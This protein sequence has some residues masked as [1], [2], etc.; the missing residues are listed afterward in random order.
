MVKKISNFINTTLNIPRYVKRF[1][2]IT[3]D[4]CLSVISLWIAFYLR[5]DEFVY[6]SGNIS[7]VAL[8]SILISIPIFWMMNMY[9]SIFRY[10]G[11]SELITVFL[12]IVVYGM[13]FF[14]IIVIYSIP[15]I[16]RSIGILQPIVYFFAISASRLTARFILNEYSKTFKNDINIQNT[17]VYGAGLAGRQISLLL[18]KNV[19]IKVFGY[20]DDNVILQGQQINGQNIYS[21]E[22]AQNIIPK[23]KISHILLAIPSLSRNKRKKLIDKIEILKVKIQTLPSISDMMLGKLK[24]SDIKDLDIEDVLGRDSVE[25]NYKLLSRNTSDK[26]V[27]ITGAGGS[28]GSELCR[29]VLKL[30]PRNLILVDSSEHSLYEI[31]SEID[32]IKKNNKDY[33]RVNIF[34][35]LLSIRNLNHLD[36]IFKTFNPDT[37][38]HAA[39]Y[40]HVPIVEENVN[41]GIDN[42]VIGTL[43]LAKITLNNQVKDLVFIS[44]DKAV[45]PTNIMGASKRLSEICLQSLFKNQ[46]NKKTKLSIVRFGNV[47]NSSGSVIPK[48]KKQ[49]IDG[50]P[51]TLTHENVTRYFMTISE[52]AQLVIQ[53]GGLSSGNDIFLLDMGEPIKIK[54]LIQKVV[55]LSGLTLRDEKNLEGDIDIEIIGL[56][57]G[58]KLFEELLISNKSEITEHSKIFK[59]LDPFPEWDELKFKINALEN[60][61]NSGDVECSVQLLSELVKEYNFNNKIFDHLYICKKV[62]NN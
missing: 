36:E 47:L 42:N 4:I 22:E 2:V 45:R 58:E 5:L 39:A 49:L 28:I 50:G 43:E 44:S 19:D 61:I 23:K 37:V 60:S 18:E 52:A 1:I 16:P 7:W 33:L 20:I 56:R 13:I 10:S 40:K 24:I 51:V 6:L 35:F 55:N 59:A 41:I 15:G 38:Y 9:K 46:S 17:L 27:L 8:I 3:N 53:A 62:K 30:M 29:Q 12:A 48:L 11:R 25:P 57:P 54:D 31:H 34:P 21:F 32:E 14:F 26:T